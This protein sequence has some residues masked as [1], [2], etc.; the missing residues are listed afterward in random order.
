MHPKI[1]L[2]LNS[3]A[4]SLYC[5]Q[6]ITLAIKLSPCIAMK[7][8]PCIAIKLSP[9]IAIKILPYIIYTVA[10]HQWVKLPYLIGYTKGF[11][12]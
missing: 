9:C 5:Y 10:L 11:S 8:S 1:V 7:L 3:T 6:T 4:I 12:I 2:L